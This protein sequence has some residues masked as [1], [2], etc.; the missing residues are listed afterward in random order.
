MVKKCLD[1]VGL[2]ITKR[3][4]KSLPSSDQSEEFLHAERGRGNLPLRQA[5]D[6]FPPSRPG[7]WLEGNN[8]DRMFKILETA[9]KMDQRTFGTAGFQFGNDK[10]YSH[11]IVAG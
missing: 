6:Q 7:K 8:G 9:G 11:G 10:A 4:P 3:G 1:K 5:F 2:E